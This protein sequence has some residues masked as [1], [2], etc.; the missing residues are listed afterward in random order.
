M[1]GRDPTPPFL[2]AGLSSAVY[3]TCFTLALYFILLGGGTGGGLE[4][5]LG[6]GPPLLPYGGGGGGA[7][8]REG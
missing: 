7:R 4:S 5:C 2:L 3:L 1:G 6:R 8:S